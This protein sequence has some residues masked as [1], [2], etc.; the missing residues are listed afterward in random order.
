MKC[1]ELT[2]EKYM[3]MTFAK[4]SEGRLPRW[5]CFFCTRSL[6]KTPIKLDYCRS[7]EETLW[8]NI[9]LTSH[10]NINWRIEKIWK[11][12]RKCCEIV[13]ASI[14]LADDKS[15][16]WKQITSARV[17]VRSKSRSVMNASRKR[18]LFIPHHTS[19]STLSSLLECKHCFQRRHMVPTSHPGEPL[20]TTRL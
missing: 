18:A 6:I 20:K 3:Y 8:W 14:F 1:A 9:A 2:F 13:V 5:V 4:V 7:K 17:V 16:K 11:N 10:P 15:R 19:V 12:R